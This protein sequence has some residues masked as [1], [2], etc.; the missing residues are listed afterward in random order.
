MKKKAD[1][2]S[3]LAG[4]AVYIHITKIDSTVSVSLRI[5]LLMTS[6]FFVIHNGYNSQT[7]I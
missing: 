3:Y 7:Q 6:A 2:A 1:W 4:I 5:P